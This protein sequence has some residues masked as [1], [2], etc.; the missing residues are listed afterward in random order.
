MKSTTMGV[1]RWIGLAGLVV[2]FS[3]AGSL[4]ALAQDHN[5]VSFGHADQQSPSASNAELPVI[6]PELR[7]DM[8]AVHGQYQRAIDAYSKIR[9]LTAEIYN[10]IGI[11]YQR[12]AMDEEA[13]ANYD[14]ASRMDRKFAAVY[15]NLGTVYFHENDNKR[16]K[17]L[18]KKS[19]KLDAQAAPFWSNLGA[20]YLAQKKYSDGAEAYERAFILDPG[21][22]QELELNGIHKDES[23]EDLAKMYLCF[24]E[25]YAHAGMKMEAIDY[26]Q[27]ALHEGFNDKQKLQQD[28]QLANLRGTPE[29]EQLLSGDHKR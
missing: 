10:K 28:Q 8:L 6:T 17:R 12:M 11:A 25:I 26:L 3:G 1:T 21:I 19:I 29:F 7:A 18:Y 22:F 16:A 14:R 24:A 23:P 4:S 9:P 2:A 5:S 13:I 27:K 15:N 20:V